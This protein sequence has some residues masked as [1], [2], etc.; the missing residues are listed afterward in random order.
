M[1]DG[2][3][4]VAVATP[5]IRLADPVYNA[6]QIADL[7]KQAASGN[8]RIAVFPEL[9]LTGYTCG[10]LFLQKTLLSGALDALCSLREASRGLD[11]LA[12]VGLPIAVRGKLYNCAAA[13][14]DGQIL[15]LIPKT[16]LPNYG[17]FSEKRYFVSGAG[18]S[19]R[20]TVGN[21][22]VFLDAHV[23]LR[24]ANLPELCVGVE[25]CEDLWVPSPPSAA[26]A[27][28]GAT[29][30]CNLSASNEL[31]AKDDHRYELIRGQ[32]SR[33]VCGYLFANA[34]EGESTQD[35]VFTGHDLICENG[36]VLAES[37]EQTGLL[38]TEIDVAMLDFA[39]RRTGAFDCS[40]VPMH[41]ILWGSDLTETVLT[42]PVARMPFVP[43]DPAARSARCEKVL[44][45]QALGLKRRIAHTN[46]GKIVIGVS[47]GLD[48]TLAMLVSARAMDMLG[49]DRKDIIS[50][51][52][53]CFG[54]TSRTRSNA[55]ILAESLGTDFRTVD[56]TA[57][58]TQ[59][60]RDIGQDPENL[61]VTFENAQA[62]ERTQVIMDIANQAGGFVV[63]TGDLSEL[64]LGWATYN[65]DHMSMY[66]VNAS[67][68][69][70][71]V[72]HLVQHCAD[73]CGNETLS[74]CLESIL[75]TPV[76]P[77][78]LPAKDGEISQITEDLVGPYALHDFFLY[79]LLRRGC[80]PAKVFRLARH[81]F[82][83]AY[84]DETIL[85][86]LRIF[87]RRFFAQQ[88]KRSCLPDGPKVGSLALSPRGDWQMPSDAVSTLWLSEL[89]ALRAPAAR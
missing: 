70:T 63:G 66:G 53:P 81:A 46:A 72:R 48:S 16:H 4:K 44:T 15:A 50:V 35:L 3:V 33:L 7:M 22:E 52:M 78:L 32:S 79:H 83:D 51:T 88:F 39:R 37:N 6:G 89:D 64:A 56:I 25:I 38:C 60:F 19:H 41:E 65:G 42:R 36:V 40:D 9:C 47:G 73:T 75:D 17:E 5:A 85:H 28:A 13:L 14:Y 1:H 26:L 86:W 11:L 61:D 34:G 71:L 68:P 12:L 74:N 77:E 84:S 59:H 24:H 76:S 49:R 27:M 62:R 20:V 10:D 69:K 23:L 18:A 58:V 80:G 2:F 30:I 57:S 54:T 8:V 67:V 55:E 43:S 87:C 31:A 45:L 82:T 21:E 29:V